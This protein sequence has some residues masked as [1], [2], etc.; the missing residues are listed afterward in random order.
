MPPKENQ[1]H[2]SFLF[3]SQDYCNIFTICAIDVFSP[4]EHTHK[5]GKYVTCSSTFMTTKMKMLILDEEG[6]E[7]SAYCSSK[8]Q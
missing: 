1:Q 3:Q 4:F 5:K 6:R 2:A 7:E 8:G